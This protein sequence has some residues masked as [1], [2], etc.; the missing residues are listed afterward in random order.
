I[1]YS[2]LGKQVYFLDKHLVYRFP[3]SLK[4]SIGWIGYMYDSSLM[5]FAKINILIASRQ[6][7]VKQGEEFNLSGKVEMPKLYSD[8]IVSHNIINDTT[9]IGIFKGQ[10]WF[11]DI[12]TKLTLKQLNSEKQFQLNVNPALPKGK[13]YLRLAINCGH[14]NPTHNSEKIGLVIE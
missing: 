1:E 12:F 3:D 14:N 13:Y 6:I 7:K 11:K 9:R 10:K 4:T 5:S 8:F 2:L